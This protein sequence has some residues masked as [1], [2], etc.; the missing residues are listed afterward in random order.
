MLIRLPL[1]VG[2][3][4]AFFTIFVLFTF[5]LNIQLDKW[6][7]WISIIAGGLIMLWQN[8]RFIVNIKRLKIPAGFNLTSSFRRVAFWSNL[9]LI[10]ILGVLF[11]SRFW[12]LKDISFPMWN[13]SVHHT[14]ITQLII[15]HSGLFNSWMPYAPYETFSMHFGFPLIS[16]LFEWLS[17]ASSEQAVLYVGQMINILAILAL[18][19]FA[20]KLARG[21]QMAGVI[22]VVVAGL[23]SPMPAFYI[24]WGRYAQLAAQVI[25]PVAL[26][27]IWD[28]ADDIQET[29]RRNWYKLPWTK[30]VLTSVVISGMLL[31]EY[32]MAYIILTFILA[33][34][35]VQFMKYR[36]ANIRFWLRE[37]SA[38]LIIGVTSI[39]LF[40]PW[41]IRIAHGNLLNYTS[42]NSNINTLLD[43]VK[44]NYLTWQNILFYVPLGIVVLALVSWVWSIAKKDW[45]ALSLG[46][47]MLLMAA[48]YSL[49][50]L[51]IPWAQYVQ[52]FAVIISLYIP[53]GLLVGYFAGTITGWLDA[54]NSRAMAGFIVVVALGFIGAWSQRN[55]SD[56]VHYGMVTQPDLQAMSWINQETPSDSLF[57]VEG[58]HENWLTN[59]VGT[60][61]GWWI[62]L[63]T[64]RQNTM[65]PQ[66]AISNEM[67]I[68]PEY[69]QKLIRLENELEKTSLNSQEGVSLICEYGITHIYIGQKQGMVGNHGQPLFTVDELSSNPNYHLVYHR[70]GVYIYS[71][72]GACEP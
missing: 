12:A 35:V 16:S 38:I 9:S 23:L 37:L 56:P 29:D 30:L 20:V 59:I 34:C 17:G 40:L 3:S 27:M 7:A 21:S 18:Y 60:D 52:S 55:I 11:F 28:I 48:V 68:E 24:N 63:L 46:I 43:L 22:T 47:W 42:F 44:Q 8:R 57:L 1:S 70:D 71:V 31:Y 66:Y 39:I 62:P 51:R 41:G 33:F 67:P 61:A 49:V 53:V 5:L 32:R 26:W 58:M 72:E 10:I 2:V 19:P 36:I 64:G 65:P 69:S 54:S 6:Y 25:L 45:L 4:M 15:D 14:V 50:L 13:D